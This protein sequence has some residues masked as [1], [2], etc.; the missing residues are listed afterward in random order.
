V[1]EGSL[2]QTTRCFSKEKRNAGFKAFKCHLMEKV[3]TLNFQPKQNIPDHT[4]R[5]DPS[6][7]E[8]PGAAVNKPFKLDVTCTW[9]GSS[10]NCPVQ[11][12]ENI[13]YLNNHCLAVA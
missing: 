7:V 10:L 4:I 2:E 12:Q 1:V 3:K 6:Q 11:L 13:Q 8:V 9:Q 5:H